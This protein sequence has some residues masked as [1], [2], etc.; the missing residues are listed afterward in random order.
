MELPEDTPCNF[1]EFNEWYIQSQKDRSR[2]VK[3]EHVGKYWI[4]TVF[5]PA[6]HG[7]DT[8]HPLLWETE[9]FNG[10]DVEDCERCTG[11][12]DQALAM[13]QEMVAKWK[14]NVIKHG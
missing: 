1:Q 6:D 12:W 8:D 13:H 14:E 7:D 11:S 5:L 4:S 10:D 9:V 2:I 3:Q